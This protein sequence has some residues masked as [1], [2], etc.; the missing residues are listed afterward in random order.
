MCHKYFS[1]L[2]SLYINDVEIFIILLRLHFIRNNFNANENIFA[3][4]I[5]RLMVFPCYCFPFKSRCEYFTLTLSIISIFTLNILYSIAF[6]SGLDCA[7]RWHFDS[8]HV[9]SFLETPLRYVICNINAECKQGHFHSYH[10][11]C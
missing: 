3:K 9:F 7:F 5:L 4:C 10:L 2:P 1:C 11:R 6:Y 8:V